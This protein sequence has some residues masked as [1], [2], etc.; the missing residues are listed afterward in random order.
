MMSQNERRNTVFAQ[1]EDLSEILALQ[2]L[3]YQSE[4][5]LVQDYSI[6][7]LLQTQS[8]IE[9]D[10]SHLMF[11]KTVVD[12]RII[13]SVRAELKGD[14]CYIG[15]VIVHPDYQNQ[16]LGTLLM[17]GIESCFGTA[18]RFELFTGERST[19]NLYF[20]QKLGYKE[21]RRE[22]LNQQVVLV[23]LEKKQ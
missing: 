10:F 15:R 21:F 23:Y 16:G 19:R 4:A 22:N 9:A 3:A 20:Y 11:L 6:P 18:S 2:K 1:F 5:E 8:E 14:T 13:G 12:G 7:P 17:A